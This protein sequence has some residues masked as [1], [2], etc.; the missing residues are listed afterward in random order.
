MEGLISRLMFAV[1]LSLDLSDSWVFVLHRYSLVLIS[2]FER[3]MHPVFVQVYMHALDRSS[4]V[5]VW[6]DLQACHILPP[7][8]TTKTNYF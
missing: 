4:G 1:A 3:G 7:P 6:F 8:V 5:D 2:S